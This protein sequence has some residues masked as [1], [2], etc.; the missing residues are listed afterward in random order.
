MNLKSE[1]EVIE[2]CLNH[3]KA[4]LAKIET[5]KDE[6]TI[7]HYLGRENMEHGI[8][9]FITKSNLGYTF[10]NMKKLLFIEAN[11]SIEDMHWFITPYQIWTASCQSQGS[12][13]TMVDTVKMR[14]KIL[15]S[16]LSNI[17]ARPSI[18]YSD[19]RPS[20]FNAL[21]N[22]EIQP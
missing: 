20:N 21:T 9:N 10:W 7:Y 4:V 22:D 13:W 8:C 12:S 15:D 2:F 11:M 1:K 19:C 18:S 16:A 5:E 3:Y 14:I 6:R 17:L